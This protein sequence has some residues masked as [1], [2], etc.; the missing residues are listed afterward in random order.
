MSPTATAIFFS[1]SFSFSGEISSKI[2]IY[3]FFKNCKV[4]RLWKFAIA[5]SRFFFAPPFFWAFL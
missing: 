3:N 4:N 2:A 5:R 1:F